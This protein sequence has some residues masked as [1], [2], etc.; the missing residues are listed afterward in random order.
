MTRRF[1]TLALTL[2]ALGAAALGSAGC[3]LGPRVIVVVELQTDMAA[4]IEFTQ[5]RTQV[6]DEVD[7]LPVALGDTFITP[8]RV[9]EL[10]SP[11]GTVR[12]RVQ[13]LDEAGLVR[14]E[15]LVIVRVRRDTGVVAF[16]SAACRR[17]QCPG[18]DQTCIDGV[19][20]RASSVCGGE[21]CEPGEGDVCTGSECDHPLSFCPRGVCDDDCAED[22]DCTSTDP[23]SEAVCE[24]RVCLGVPR[25]DACPPG[26]FCAIGIGCTDLPG[27][28]RDGG[29]PDGGGALDA[30]IDY[31]TTC[32]TSCGTPGLGRCE[33]GFPTGQCDP[34]DEY[35][36]GRDEDCD[37]RLDEGLE[38]DHAHAIV[39]Q[40]G[41]RMIPGT[42]ETEPNVVD[43]FA[44]GGPG[45]LCAGGGC[46]SVITN[47]RTLP[48][49]FDGHQHDVDFGGSSSFAVMDD[50]PFAISAT[51]HD[52]S[53][54]R[55]GA[56]CGL[57]NGSLEI[58]GGLAFHR[59]APMGADSEDMPAG[60]YDQICLAPVGDPATECYLAFGYCETQ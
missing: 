36:N 19:C 11:T 31:C 25:P 59:I 50:V 15:R 42:M 29:V 27:P 55:H 21:P 13:L 40:L 37:T 39:C 6:G 38:C 20:Q 8:A 53:G 34:P 12:V 41:R 14:G 16:I 47:C 7:T 18:E 32:T 28:L 45:L 9:A 22:A 49:G 57:G 43:S 48:G 17:V 33:D 3:G 1:V 5:V 4:G 26:F 54:H 35:C 24:S 10:R 58:E 44:G 60:R 30:G 56:R 46:D 52:T 51:V 2:A 23:C